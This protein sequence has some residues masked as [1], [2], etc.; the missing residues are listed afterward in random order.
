MPG[1][2]A[3][4]EEIAEFHAKL[5]RP[6]KAEGY[7][8]VKPDLP[9]GMEWNEGLVKWFGSTAHKLGLSKM[10]ANGIV[11][12]WN[13]NQFSE[14]H[15]AQKTSKQGLD[16]LKDSW[17]DQFDGR[18]ELGLRGVE[19]LL[20]AD[21]AIQFKSLMDS[22]GLGDNPLMLKF[23]HQVGKMLKE[24]GYIVSS[25]SGGVLGSES[26][27]AEIKSINDDLEHP[28]WNADAPGHA[29]AVE[30]MAQLFKTAYPK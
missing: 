19:R 10:Q 30:R 21:E 20:S 25:S 11:K 3:T 12:A 2:D 18:V 1:D 29:E 28:H 9:D 22:T 6:E 26:A 4:P 15:A 24:D 16:T 5:G 14:A 27:K 23:A 8:F 13:D 17:G 7:E